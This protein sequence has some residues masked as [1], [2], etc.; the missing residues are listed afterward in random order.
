ML[1]RQQISTYQDSY[2][3]S[4]FFKNTEK[5]TASLNLLLF[6]STNPELISKDIAF[7]TGRYLFYTFTETIDWRVGIIF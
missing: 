4:S 6:P 1:I 3:K 7:L 2:L 5:F